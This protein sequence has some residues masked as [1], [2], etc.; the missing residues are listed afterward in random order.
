MG[1]RVLG[2]KVMNTEGRPAENLLVRTDMFHSPKWWTRAAGI[3]SL[4]LGLS[5]LGVGCEESI[6]SS[7]CS[8][9]CGDDIC[10]ESSGTC[11]TPAQLDICAEQREAAPCRIDELVGYCRSGACIPNDSIWGR[12]W[13]F[14]ICFI[15]TTWFEDGSGRA[16]F[17]LN[18]S[19]ASGFSWPVRATIRIGDIELLS[20][21]FVAEEGSDSRE[22]TIRYADTLTLTSEFQGEEWSAAFRVDSQ[23][24]DC[25]FDGDCSSTCGNGLV[26]GEEWCDATDLRGARCV[27]FGFEG[28]VLACNL[29]CG[30]F[31]V[32]G[33]Q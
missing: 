16:G 9:S 25:H 27:D 6:G 22:Y 1:H 14:G 33:C 17:I 5:L 23:L 3:W 4:L 12:C 10:H 31:D 19:V 8:G 26:E 15:T 18:Y 24:V 21:T 13:P 20:E 11:V 29:D 32:D 7:P 28:G 2:G 30:M